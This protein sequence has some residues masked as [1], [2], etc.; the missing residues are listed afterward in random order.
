M[1]TGSIAAERAREES[2]EGSPARKARIAGMLYLIVIVGGIF[3]EI[4]VRARLVVI[5]DAAATAQNILSHAMLYRVGFAV[6]V[7]YL[8]CNVPINLLLYDLFG[9]IHRRTALLMLAFSFVGTAIEGVSLLAHYA[10]LVILGKATYLAAFTPPQ[11]HAAAYASLRLFEG[12]FAIALAFFGFFCITLGSLI[13]RSTFFPRII[14]WLLALQGSLYL[15]DSFASFISPA[16]GARVFPFLAASSL[17]GEI[18]FCLWLLVM[19]VDA[20]RWRAQLSA[21]VPA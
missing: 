1:G 10:P 9:F 17:G 3:A 19:G 12:G 16:A 8:L 2:A 6:E 7:F 20:A 13:A 18:S 15:I 14:G 4:G 21:M 5:G 11:L